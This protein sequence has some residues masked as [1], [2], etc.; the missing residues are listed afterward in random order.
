MFTGRMKEC[1]PVCKLAQ[2]TPGGASR[3]AHCEHCV[4]EEGRG[5][6]RQTEACSARGKRH[7]ECQTI[8]K[9]FS[10]KVLSSKHHLGHI[11]Q[12]RGI[13]G[14]SV[15]IPYSIVGFPRAHQLLNILS[16]FAPHLKLLQVC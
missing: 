7:S 12:H 3:A 14:Y 6:Q 13:L 4:G 11:E 10:I 1:H 15:K 5:Q 9:T 16:I 2:M 8:K